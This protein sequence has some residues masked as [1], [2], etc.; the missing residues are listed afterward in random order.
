[1]ASSRKP[2]KKT[3]RVKVKYATIFAFPRPKETASRGRVAKTAPLVFVAPETLYVR[4]GDGIEW[5]L[6]NVT[7]QSYK[8]SFTWKR[9]SP[10]K[11]EPEQFERNSGIVWVSP[12]AE[13]GPYKYD[14]LFNGK[15]V[16]DPEIEI[17]P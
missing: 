16:L 8:V 17:M 13:P 10:L 11:G 6:V 5:T 2:R 9:T 1:M 7:D 3:K 14:V 12:D 15:P 4:P